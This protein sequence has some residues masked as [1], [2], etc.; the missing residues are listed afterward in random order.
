MKILVY[1][2]HPAK[3]HFFKHAISR[4]KAD[5]HEVRVLIKTKDILEQ[6]LCEDH[7]EYKNIQKTPRKNT[8]WSMLVASLKRSWSVYQEARHFRADLLVG[9]DASIAQSAWL[10]HKP[11]ITTLEDDVEIIRNLARLTYPFTSDI[12]VPSVCRV[13][14]WNQKKIGY[15][16]YMKL[17]YLHPHYFQPDKSVIEKYGIRNRF[18]LIRLARLT[19]Y[20]DQ[21]IKGLNAALVDQIL[22]MAEKSGYGIYISSESDMEERLKPYQLKIRHTDIHHVMAF[23]SLLISDSQSMSVEAAM[24][25]TP[26]LRFSDFS[27]RISVLEELE[28]KY[29]LT[30]GIKTSEPQRLLN[31]M[32]VL[33]ERDT[34]A[35]F[36]ERRERMISEKI[37]VTAFLIWYLEHY[38]DSR[39]TMKEDPDFQYKFQ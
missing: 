25:G 32:K 2:G 14:K 5:G 22:V 34:R 1:I 10:L 17:A 30:L 12:L 4:L 3:Y 16:G 6:L 8:K 7:L 19:A 36:R 35:I 37:D 18:I 9:S 27:G 23:A 39:Q 24:L 20:H 11:A 38:P 29:G 15:D 13:G 33:L 28:Y 26:N 21:G 31:E